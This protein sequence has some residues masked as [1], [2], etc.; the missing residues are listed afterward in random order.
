LSCPSFQFAVRV[1]TSGL[2][3]TALSCGADGAEYPPS[4]N[5]AKVMEEVLRDIKAKPKMERAF[6]MLRP[7]GDKP[8][9]KK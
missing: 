4:F 2:G 1:N 9:E 8:Q 3:V 6:P 7:A 5:P